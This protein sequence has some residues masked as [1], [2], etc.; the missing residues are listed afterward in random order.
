M[1]E[2]TLLSFEQFKNLPYWYSPFVRG[3][4]QD[5]QRRKASRFNIE[6]VMVLE[7]ESYHTPQLAPTAGK[8]RLHGYTSNISL[9]FLECEA[10]ALVVVLAATT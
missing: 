3:F 9:L 1:S 7:H 5:L 6:A 10:D 4:V 8:K 2:R